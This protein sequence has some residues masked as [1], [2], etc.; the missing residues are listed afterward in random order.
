MTVYSDATRRARRR[1][2]RPRAGLCL[3]R[4]AAPERGTTFQTPATVT[5]ERPSSAAGALTYFTTIFDLNIDAVIR[6]AASSSDARILSTPVILTTDNTEAKIVVGEERPVVTS[7]STSDGGP[8]D[9]RVRVP[10]HR[11]QPDRD[12]AHQPPAVRRDG[13]HADGGQRRRVRE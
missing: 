8:A 3:R 11:H 10:Q 13:D 12:A 1:R 2:D 6:M 4:R 5:R 9:V 7:T